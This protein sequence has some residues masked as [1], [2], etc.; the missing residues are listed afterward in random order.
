M[1]AAMGDML[2]GCI[3]VADLRGVDDRIDAGLQLPAHHQ[4]GLR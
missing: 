1:L 4:S 3:A 2:R